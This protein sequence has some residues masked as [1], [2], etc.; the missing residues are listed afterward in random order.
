MSWNKFSVNI[1][2]NKPAG[3][4][5][6]VIGKK[7][8]LESEAAGKTTTLKTSEIVFNDEQARSFIDD[9]K[10]GE[11]LISIKREGIL[12]NIKGFYNDTIGK[13]QVTDGERR[14]RAAIKLGIEEVK[15]FVFDSKVAASL[16]AISSN[17]FREDIHPIDKGIEVQSIINRFEEI[18]C[19]Y[20]INE[21]A[22]YF[23]VTKPTIYEW[24]RYSKLDKGVRSKVVEFDVRNKTVLRRITKIVKLFS[25]S[26]LKDSDIQKEMNDQIDSVIN[27]YINKKSMKEVSK[28]S[29]ITSTSVSNFLYYDRGKD[30]F[31][32]RESYKKLSDKDKIR[33]KEK[34]EQLINLLGT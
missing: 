9:K 15:F 28:K 29:D 22:E 26:D 6:G 4:K 23:N 25:S 5:N 18:G 21:I 14:L 17:Q 8:S 27:N 11:L 13:Y 3:S 33:L 34:A 10:F 1:T 2:P 12:N 30:E 24:L 16:A 31:I 20:S 7:T 32:L 19:D